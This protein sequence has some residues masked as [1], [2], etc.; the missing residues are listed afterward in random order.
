MQYFHIDSS[1]KPA[2][3]R[4][5]EIGQTLNASSRP[6]NPYYEQM[7]D[8]HHTNTKAIISRSYHLPLLRLRSWW[9]QGRD[10]V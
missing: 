7:C 1:Y 2:G 6:S 4:L 10:A 8:I 9:R 3:K 5:L